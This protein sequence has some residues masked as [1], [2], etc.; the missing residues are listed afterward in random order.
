MTKKYHFIAI[1]GAVMH[2]L[3]LS[4][5]AKGY[6]VTGSDDEIYEPSRTRLEKAGI[7]PKE[8]GWFPEKIHAGLDGIILGMHARIEN[9]E[10]QKAKDLNIPIFSFPEFIYE[11][12]KDKKRVVISGSHGKTSITSMILHVLKFHQK[13]FDYLVGAQIEGFDLMVKLSN[14]PVIII[15]GDEYLTS[16]LDRRPKFFH[17]HHDILLMSGIAWDHFNVFP[18]FD[19]YREQFEKLVEMTPQQGY[20]IYCSEDPIVDELGQKSKG[21]IDNLIPYKAHPYKIKEGIT[22]LLTDSGDIAITVFGEHNLQNLQGALE[23]CL[24]LGL[25]KE[26]FYEAVQEF[27]GAAKRQEVLAKSDQSI[28]Y[29]DFAHAPSKLQATVNAVKN[30]FPERKLIAVQELHTY[31]SLNKDFVNNY[32]H[33]FDEAD[34]A[35]IY[36]NPKAV[37]LKKLELMDEDT[38]RDAFKRNDLKL[39]TDIDQLKVF[40]ESQ[41]YRQANLLLMSSGNYDDMDLSQLKNTINQSQK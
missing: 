36:L 3:A 8:K 12:S 9:P 30:Q 20:F 18:T 29:R 27:K 16:P 25:T 11:Q 19:F 1:G 38:L 33:T 13:E 21:K 15:E 24:S 14:A 5:V 39:F 37:S 31:S 32:A 40:L 22:Y 2:N 17:Y 28:L 10:L 4:M 35:V 23:V 7:L 41:D 6:Q 34:V 26:Q